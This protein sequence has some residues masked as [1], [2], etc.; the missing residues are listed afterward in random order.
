MHWPTR[1]GR[2]DR[3]SHCRGQLRL[4][5]ETTTSCTVTVEA[6]SADGSTA[7]T[8]FTVT[9][10]DVDDTAPVFTS[11]SSILVNEN[12]QDVVDLT[13]TDADSTAVHIHIV[14]YRR[15]AL[16]GHQAHFGSHQHLDRT[17]VHHLHF[18]PMRRGRH[19]D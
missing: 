8:T 2:H 11:D 3:N 13:V 10:T 9:I 7:A 12:V 1:C 15:I 6:A 14:G 4:D 5:A 19:R 18:Q 16:R 17:R